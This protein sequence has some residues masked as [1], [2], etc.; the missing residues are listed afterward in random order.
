MKDCIDEK[1]KSIVVR[2]SN[3]RADIG[4]IS[5]GT[6]FIKDLR[7]DSLK[8]VEMLV[9]IEIEFGIETGIEHL[10][11]NFANNYSEL[12]EFVLNCKKKQKLRGTRDA[13]GHSSGI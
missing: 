2:H 10:G 1:L 8:L 7:F 3:V 12:R 4:D 11:M 6:E 9:H 13:I 5:D